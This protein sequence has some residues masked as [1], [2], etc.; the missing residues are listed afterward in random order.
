MHRNKTG[1]A[2]LPPPIQSRA[3]PQPSQ[4]LRLGSSPHEINDASIT[5]LSQC[6]SCAALVAASHA[7]AVPRARHNGL[8]QQGD[9]RTRALQRAARR[10][11]AQRQAGGGTHRPPQTLRS[12]DEREAEHFR[13]CTPLGGV[14]R[15]SGG[16]GGATGNVGDQHHRR[17]GAQ[18]PSVLPGLNPIRHL[19]R[20]ALQPAAWCVRRAHKG[21]HTR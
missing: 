16:V 10:A 20:G 12:F 3:E 17:A 6:L 13:L 5:P 4:P 21:G 11:R 9:A 1:A 15:H 2:S 14:Q 18:Q 7:A 8:T 19:V